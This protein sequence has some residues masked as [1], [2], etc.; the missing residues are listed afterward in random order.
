MKMSSNG[1]IFRVTGHMYGE[2]TG[3]RR[4]PRTK[5]IDAELRCI[6]FICAW[7]NDWVNNGE[8]GDLRRHRAHYH[9]IIMIYKTGIG[10]EHK[11]R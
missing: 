8:A 2:L 10:L 6:F 5:A 7:L 4:I 9:V 1:N 3:H 11:I